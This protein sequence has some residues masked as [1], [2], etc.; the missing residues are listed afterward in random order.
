MITI[1]LSILVAG[2]IILSGYRISQLQRVTKKKLYSDLE[3]KRALLRSGYSNSALLIASMVLLGKT[4]SETEETWI[5]VVSGISFIGALVTL[6]SQI[7]L[8]IKN[9][10]V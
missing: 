6:F 8:I 5:L 9:L 2:L 7:R 10:D 1:I 3:L 4:C